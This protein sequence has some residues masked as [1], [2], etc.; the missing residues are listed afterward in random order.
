MSYS[1]VDSEVDC[2]HKDQMDTI[3][4]DIK[5]WIKGQCGGQRSGSKV[6]VKG[7]C[8]MFAR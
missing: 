4:A 2:G 1:E 7:Q 8:Q 6:E 3:N 5:I